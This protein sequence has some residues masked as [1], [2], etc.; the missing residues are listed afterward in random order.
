MKNTLIALLTCSISIHLCHAQTSGV[1]AFREAVAFPTGLAPTSA[2]TADLNKDG[3]PDLVVANNGDSNISVLLNQGFAKFKI[4]KYPVSIFPVVAAVADFNGDGLPDIAVTDHD[5]VSILLGCGNGL[6]LPAKSNPA[7][8]PNQ[9]FI[10]APTG[11]AV[12]DFNGDGIPD[13]AVTD[14]LNNTLNILVGD[15]P[16][17]S[18]CSTASNSTRRRFPLLSEISTMTDDWILPL[19][20]T[21]LAG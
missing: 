13:L 1:V 2:V 11:L 19:P 6:F 5:G 8:P 7:T 12:G 20:T 21:W 18:L 3:K 9:Q 4:A 17:L 14:S 10:P 16:A 15:G